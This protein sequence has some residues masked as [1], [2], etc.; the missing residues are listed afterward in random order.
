MRWLSAALLLSLCFFAISCSGDAPANSAAPASTPQPRP[1]DFRETV[2]VELYTSEG[3]PNCPL[4]DS[5]LA[6]INERQPVDGADIVTLSLHVDYFNNRG[7]Q[8]PFSSAKFT[9][10]QNR[11]AARM[12]LQSIYTPQMIVDGQVE[13]VG[14][15]ARKA[16]DAV[17]NALVHRKADVELKIANGKAEVRIDNIPRHGPATVYF[18]V[19]ENGLESQVKAG[20]NAGKSIKHTSIVRA[21]DSLGQLKAEDTMYQAT[22]DIK[23]DPSWKLDNLKYVVFIQDEGTGRVIAAA[24]RSEEK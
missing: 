10:R 11:Y 14:S 4:A 23:I 20:P 16:S 5:M 6:Y 2:I 22:A 24:S 3:C 1:P 17:K 12:G 21:L 19:A 18:A 9:Q 13:F 7:W 15:D 8:D